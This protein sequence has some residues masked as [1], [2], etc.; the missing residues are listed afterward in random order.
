MTRYTNLGLKRTHVQPEFNF[1]KESSND[2]K[3]E[4]GQ[5]EKHH[6]TQDTKIRGRKKR[7]ILH[8][9]TSNTDGGQVGA[10]EVDRETLDGRQPSGDLEGQ[11]RA[12]KSEKAKKVK[13]KMNGHQQFK[14]AKGARCLSS[15]ILAC[16]NVSRVDT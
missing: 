15:T 12:V 16:K 14:K 9:E 8:Q 5:N 4:E 7:E 13:S 2:L 10:S 6:N 3:S 1:R 11:K